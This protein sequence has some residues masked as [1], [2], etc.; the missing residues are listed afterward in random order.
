MKALKIFSLLAVILT[1]VQITAYAHGEDDISSAS[2]TYKPE[3][4]AKRLEILSYAIDLYYQ[5][6]INIKTA[7]DMQNLKMTSDLS[8]MQSEDA[9]LVTG[10]EITKADINQAFRDYKAEL[11]ILSLEP[12]SIEI[13]ENLKF[14]YNI[15]LMKAFLPRYDVAK[16][17]GFVF[18][19]FNYQNTQY[20]D[21]LVTRNDALNLFYKDFTLNDKTKTTANL[22]FRISSLIKIHNE[23]TK[24]LNRNRDANI[25]Q[26]YPKKVKA[27]SLEE[28]AF[29]YESIIRGETLKPYKEATTTALP[30]PEEIKTEQEAVKLETSCSALFA[31]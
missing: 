16:D 9:R 2:Q 19:V 4:L 22:D 8:E 13:Y 27:K 15:V 21:E 23:I 18:R 30:A 26:V 31:N 1:L 6:V 7:L 24:K 3:R 5:E 10:L 12:D 29:I 11:D 14:L 28:E 17:G 25:F 20:A